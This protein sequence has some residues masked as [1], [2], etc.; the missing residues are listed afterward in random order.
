MSFD[1]NQS[2]QQPS[3]IFNYVNNDIPLEQLMYSTSPL[4]LIEVAETLNK[5]QDDYKYLHFQFQ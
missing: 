2:S 5:P 1:Q 3:P 4:W